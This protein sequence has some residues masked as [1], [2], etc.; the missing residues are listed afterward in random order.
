MA[1][2]RTGLITLTTYIETREEKE[3]DINANSNL[4]GTAQMMRYIDQQIAKAHDEDKES[5]I[6]Y[7]VGNPIQGF[8]DVKVVVTI[9][10]AKGQKQINVDVSGLE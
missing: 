4:S 7:K 9:E 3:M 5:S 2:S 6:N 1:I 8:T 10:M